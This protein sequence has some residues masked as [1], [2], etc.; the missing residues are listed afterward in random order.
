MGLSWPISYR[1][2]LEP[3]LEPTGSFFW[4][5]CDD[6]LEG[7]DEKARKNNGRGERI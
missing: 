4:N 3:I 2:K 1:E 6:S 5:Q 7:S